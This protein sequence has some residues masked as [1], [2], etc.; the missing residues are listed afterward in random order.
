MRDNE[1][2]LLEA[3]FS[4]VFFWAILGLGFHNQKVM[5]QLY[6]CVTLT[7][8]CLKVI[9][10]TLLDKQI[11]ELGLGLLYFTWW[12]TMK[13]GYLKY[14]SSIFSLRHF[15]VRVSQWIRNASILSLCNPNPNM[16]QNK[17]SKNLPLISCFDWL[18]L[19]NIK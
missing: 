3:A 4:Y 6:D 9:I 13:T 16:S 1:N 8:I 2:R 18:S 19:Y 7:Q 15:R 5:H 17:H 12:E 14:V 11:M 10:Y